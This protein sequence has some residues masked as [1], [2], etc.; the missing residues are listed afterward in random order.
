[1]G[2]SHIPRNGQYELFIHGGMTHCFDDTTLEPFKTPSGMF[3]WLKAQPIEVCRPYPNDE[4][5][6]IT[7]WYL[8]PEMYLLWK[9]KWV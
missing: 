2:M 6:K 3:E 8:S 4:A 5:L 7:A 1:M 9:L